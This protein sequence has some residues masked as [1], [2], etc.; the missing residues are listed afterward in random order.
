MATFI[1]FITEE[2]FNIIICYTFFCRTWCFAHL[3]EPDALPIE[4]SILRIFRV[5][6]PFR[7]VRI[8]GLYVSNAL[9]MLAF[10]QVHAMILYVCECSLIPITATYICTCISYILRF[11]GIKFVTYCMHVYVYV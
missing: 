6:R 8:S 10:L 1:I 11:W 4:I 5:L 3:Y 7:A 9:S 2:K